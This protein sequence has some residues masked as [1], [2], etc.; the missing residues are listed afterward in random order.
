[1]DLGEALRTTGAVREYTDDPVDDATVYRLLETARFAPNGGNRQAWRVVVVRDP[2]TRRALRDIYLPGWYEYLAQVSVGL[3]PWAVVTDRGLEASSVAG[4]GEIAAAA[5]A[6]PGG[7][8]E[9][10][11]EVP[12]MLVLLADLTR[13]AT[14]DRDSGHYTLVGGASIY[15]FAWSILLAAR[16]EGLAGVMTTM[17]VRDERAVTELLGVP[18]T[19]TVAGLLALGHPVKQPT[20]LRRAAVEEFATVDRFD[21]PPLAAG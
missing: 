16:N 21:G 15:P 3:T 19:H 13:L 18:D 4:A 7:F 14:V 2:A 10:L 5:A 6:G 1:M 8:A 11:D 20:R 17:V 9:H 12:A